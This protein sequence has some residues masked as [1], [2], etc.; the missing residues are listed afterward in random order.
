DDPYNM[1]FTPDGK[2]AMV[3]AEARHR[4][5]L[6]DP[7]TMKLVDAVHVDCA[8][9]DHVDFTADNKYAIATC[10]FSGKLVKID[11][12]SHKPIAYLQ[13][14]KPAMPQDIR[15]SPDGSVFYVADMMA[16]GAH[17]IDPV[18]FK[19]I[20]FIKMGKGTHGIVVGRGGQPFYFTN[21]GWN[22]VLGGHRGPGS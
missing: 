5:D 14:Q 16:D 22:T 8:G 3:I 15:V 11:L 2:L 18:A 13:L 7:I 10:E 1:Y 12:A 19:E 9:L 17:V 20:E 4:F 6:R 21:R